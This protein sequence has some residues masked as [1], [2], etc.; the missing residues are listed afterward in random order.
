MSRQ[1]R[2]HN[3]SADTWGDHSPMVEPRPNGDSQVPRF[4]GEPGKPSECLDD[5]PPASGPKAVP[6]RRDPA[7][8]AHDDDNGRGLRSAIGELNPGA[9]LRDA[10][11]AKGLSLE[12]LSRTTKIAI[13]ILKA[14]EESNVEK[15]PATIFTRGF[16]KSYAA[17]VGL[18]PEETAD[19]YLAQLA[20]ETLAVDGETA[21][22]KVA[23]PAHRSEVLAYDD[24]TSLYLAD[25]QAGRLGWLVTTA[26]VI[27]LAV[28]IWS[29]GWRTDT[30]PEA[31]AAGVE[32]AAV[33][34]ASA[35]AAVASGTSMG[36]ATPAISAI[37][38]PI[39]PLRFVLEPHGPCWLAAGADG[40][41][42]FAR[43]LQAGERETIEVYDE[44]V[45]RV[46]DPGALSFSINGRRGRAVGQPGEPVNVR[47]TKDNF[48]E[49]L[50]AQ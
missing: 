25:R 26:A 22:L 17:E 28:Y 31:T 20:P 36:D 32:A 43:L 13:G 24:D 21:R 11:K 23:T 46:G 27:G 30:E 45:L 5:S 49:F 6:A 37:E 10:R 7:A 50:A 12:D 1:T 4:A 34:P 44:L 38:T 19:L 9:A 47:I 48:R 18:D 35:D 14:L 3:H 29:F 16:L 42:V 41:P 8:P 40:N 2:R 33:Q 15:L 39:G